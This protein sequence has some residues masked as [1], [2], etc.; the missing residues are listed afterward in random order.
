MTS[1]VSSGS[2]PADPPGTA[3]RSA[4]PLVFAWAAVLAMVA[5]WLALAT[6]TGLIF[7]FL[8]GATFLAAAFVFRSLEHGRRASL[9]EIVVLLFGGAVGSAIGLLA[10][11]ALGRPL[12]DDWATTL[13]VIAGA[14]L[15]ILWLCRRT[16]SI[17]A[18]PSI[19]RR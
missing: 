13:V 14:A 5:V 8:P 15:A 12:D 11:R 2:Q 18:G 6:Q 16:A 7:H 3:A 10:V 17:D 4:K 1:K 9:L 19:E